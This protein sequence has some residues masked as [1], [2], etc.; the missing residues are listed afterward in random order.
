MTKEQIA[1]AEYFPHEL[2][3]DVP[4]REGA[5]AILRDQAARIAASREMILDPHGRETEVHQVMYMRSALGPDG[6]PIAV[7][8]TQ[9]HA[10]FVKLRL[11]CWAMAGQEPS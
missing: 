8:T 4:A 3:D 9:E 7:E 10:E 5:W 1:A 11:A 6:V 2:W